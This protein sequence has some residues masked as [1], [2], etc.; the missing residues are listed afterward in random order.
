M[1]RDSSLPRTC[2]A[3]GESSKRTFCAVLNF[4]RKLF[5]SS[6]QT[7]VFLLKVD[8]E[9]LKTRSLVVERARRNLHSQQVDSL[10]SGVS[11]SNTEP[12]V[13]VQNSYSSLSSF[14][15]LD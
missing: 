13:T 4:S 2:N 14:Y 6:M 12:A 5:A 15:C 1:L 9:E 8:N 11:S 3:F 7:S 10:K